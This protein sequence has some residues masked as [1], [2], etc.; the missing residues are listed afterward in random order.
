ML[1]CT[2][3]PPNTRPPP[4]GRRPAPRGRARGPL[5]GAARHRPYR[6][7]GG[8]RLDLVRR[9]PPVPLRERGDSWAMGGVDHARRPGRGDGA[10]G[11]RPARRGDRVPPP[12]HARQAGGDGGRDLRRPPGAGPGRRLEP[13]GV[14]RAGRPLRPPDQPVRGGVHDRPDPAPRRL[15]RLRGRVLHGSRCG[16][17]AAT[18]PP[19]RPGDPHRLQRP[20]HARGH[21]A[22]RARVER[23]V[24]GH[25]QLA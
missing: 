2:H 10:R 15:H 1:A 9:P 19:G 12:V 25:P 11:D 4:R 7:A 5:A 14:R 23:L 22:V 17:A 24:R 18:G 8:L 6:R 16:A 3:D 13:R 20:S 21:A